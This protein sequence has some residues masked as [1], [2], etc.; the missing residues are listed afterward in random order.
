M[1]LAGGYSATASC[2]GGDAGRPQLAQGYETERVTACVA[3]E[4]GWKSG[5]SNFAKGSGILRHDLEG[6]EVV[7]AEDSL[8]G[9]KRSGWD[10]TMVLRREQEVTKAQKVRL[11]LRLRV[12]CLAH[13][14]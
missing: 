7:L 13:R 11:R 2:S 6:V 10:L 14:E 5:A 4:K 1:L 12:G 9:Q 8:A 3:E